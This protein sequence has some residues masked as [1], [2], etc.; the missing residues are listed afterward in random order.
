MIDS[1]FSLMV[2][3]GLVHSVI[4]TLT[5]LARITHMATA[6]FK[7]TELSSWYLGALSPAKVS[8]MGIGWP[9]SNL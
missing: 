7:E 8:R 2:S 3:R 6:I 5:S 4:S 9:M 1:G